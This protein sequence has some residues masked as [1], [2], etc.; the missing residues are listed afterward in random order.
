MVLTGQCEGEMLLSAELDTPLTGGKKNLRVFGAI[1]RT[2]FG[3]I[4]YIWLLVYYL[5]FL[6]PF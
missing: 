6:D 4:S 5:Y 3:Y 1:V 2:K